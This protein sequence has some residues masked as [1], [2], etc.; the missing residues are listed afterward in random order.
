M[1]F[2][3]IRKLIREGLQKSIIS[4]NIVTPPD[5]PGTMNFFHGGNLNKYDDIILFM[6]CQIFI[7][8]RC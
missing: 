5:I 3:E 7:H 2:K 6:K 1:E 8:K 4:E